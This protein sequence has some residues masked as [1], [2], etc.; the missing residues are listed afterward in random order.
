M[1]NWLGDNSSCSLFLTDIRSPITA[2]HWRYSVVRR[3][4][5]LAYE[6]RARVLTR[7]CKTCEVAHRY[8]WSFHLLVRS[9]FDFTLLTPELDL[10][11]FDRNEN[12]AVDW[13]I[14]SLDLGL[15]RHRLSLCQRHSVIDS[16][17]IR[18]SPM[19]RSASMSA[20]GSNVDLSMNSHLHTESWNSL[21]RF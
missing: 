11:R 10:V 7:Y 4:S 2:L 20:R 8:S 12:V 1:A 17:I 3:L 6:M 21:H 14:L 15:S 9:R 19:S 13:I 18:P 16:C 5:L